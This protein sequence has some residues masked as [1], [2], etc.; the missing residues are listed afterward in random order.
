MPSLSYLD[1][2][3]RADVRFA[4]HAGSPPSPFVLVHGLAR[5]GVQAALLIGPPPV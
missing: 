1:H 5:D 2:P 4:R 3:L